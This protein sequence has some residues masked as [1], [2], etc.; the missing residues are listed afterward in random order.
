MIT[1]FCR[2]GSLAALAVALAFALPAAP[3]AAQDSPDAELAARNQSRAESRPVRIEDHS[4]PV[5]VQIERPEPP[6][7]APQPEPREAPRP[8]RVEGPQPETFAVS[9]PE[10]ATKPQPARF[11]APRP[12]Q[13]PEVELRPSARA[14]RGFGADVVARAQAA[15]RAQ[16]RS[17]QRAEQTERRGDVRADQ[18]EG[19]SR[20]GAAEQVDGRANARTGQTERRSDVRSDGVDNVGDRRAEGVVSRRE[21]WR[22]ADGRDGRRDDWRDGRRDQSRGDRNNWRRDDW[23][24]NWNGRPGWDQR[25]YRRWDSRWRAN[26]SYNWGDYRHG[27]QFLF[28]PGPYFA[29]YRSHRYNRIDIGFYL[30]SLFFQ[31]RY[32]INDPWSYRLPPAHGPYQWVRYYD[33]VLLVDIYSGQVVDVIR[34]FF[35]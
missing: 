23:R 20:D 24:W 1:L 16:R 2:G 17:E 26:R 15:E 33:D 28:R 18:L 4:E 21:D 30:D 5:T 19:R 11:A 22:G 13:T 8:E 31:P 29:P 25:D 32:F 7:A 14:P 10:R 9:E 12:A 34:N 35:W 27:N 6:R 3:A